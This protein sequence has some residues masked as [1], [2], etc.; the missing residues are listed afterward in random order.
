MITFSVVFFMFAFVIYLWPV[1]S[2]YGYLKRYDENTPNFFL[3]NFRPVF[4]LRRYRKLTKINSGQT[5]PFYFFWFFSLGITILL[6]LL[7]IF[8]LSIR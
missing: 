4:F 1:L 3:L 2:I 7:G 5:G 8:C 6:I